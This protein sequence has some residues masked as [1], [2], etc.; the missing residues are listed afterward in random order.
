MTGSLRTGGVILE[1]TYQNTYLP[2]GYLL[3]SPENRELISSEAGLK[4]AALSGKILEAPAVMCDDSLDL[5]IALGGKIRG[6]IPKNESVY[7]P[8]GGDIKDIAVITRVGRPVSFKV[9]EIREERGESIAILSRR[10]AQIECMEKYLMKLRIGDIISARITHLEQFGAFCDIGCGIIALIPIDCVSVSRVPHTSNRFRQGMTVKVI[11]KDID[12]L[13][14]RITLSHKELLGTWQ[15]NSDLFMVGQTVP[16]TVRGV[17]EYGI[18]IELTP[19]LAGLAEYRPG[20]EA[21]MT[22]AV[23]I[24]SI[25]AERMKVKLVIV[26]AYCTEQIS[27]APKYFLTDTDHIDYWRYSPRGCPRIIE[28]NFTI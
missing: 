8:N 22:A 9:M 4:H 14:G 12:H 1:R 18:F 25:I 24:K 23:Y 7:I 28:S 6:I 17:E 10:A 2:E 15:E 5:S 11:I 26:D 3:N 20:I 16:G 13:S 21:G 27:P 19:N